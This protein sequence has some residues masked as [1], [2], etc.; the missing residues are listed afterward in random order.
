M[1]EP[2]LDP[3]EAKMLDLLRHG[4]GLDA[5]PRAWTGCQDRRRAVERLVK[6]GFARFVEPSVCAKHGMYVLSEEAKR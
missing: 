1:S 3:L 4:A 6:K 2:A 5:N